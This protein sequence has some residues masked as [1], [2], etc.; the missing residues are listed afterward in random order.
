MDKMPPN[1]GEPQKNTWLRFAQNIVIV[2]HKSSI[3]P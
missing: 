2:G 1:F 3:Q